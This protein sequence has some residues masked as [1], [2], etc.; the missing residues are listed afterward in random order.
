MK[1]FAAMLIGAACAW[2]ATAG[3]VAAMPPFRKAFEDKY[4]KEHPKAEFQ[5]AAKKAMCNICH[6]QGKPKTVNNAYGEELA[7]LIEGKASDRLKKAGDSGK[8]AE[9]EKLLA[10]LEAAFAKVEKVKV[11][12]KDSASPT[13][14]DLIK[15]GKLPV[16]ATTP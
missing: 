14:G 5:A 4:V 8:E 11:D 3:T 1:K 13:Y 7:K 16:E 6:V 9:Q 2:A 12:S 10:E 15:A